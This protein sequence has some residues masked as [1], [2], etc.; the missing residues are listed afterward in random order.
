M[1][2]GQPILLI[3]LTD[4]R[5]RFH[6]LCVSICSNEKEADYAFI[7]EALKEGLKTLFNYDW[8]PDT[9]MADGAESITN[10]FM[11]AFGYTSTDQFTRLMCWPHVERNCTKNMPPRF[12]YATN[13]IADI[14]K[15]Q[16]SHCK[17]VFNELYIKFDAKWKTFGGRL[18]AQV[19]MFLQYF[20][21][22]WIDTV[23]GW[24]HGFYNYH[25]YHIM[26]VAVRER[27]LQI[28]LRCM[29]AEIAA[30]AKRGRKRRAVGGE[31]LV[32]PEE[33]NKQKGREAKKSRKSTSEAK[34]KQ[35]KKQML[36]KLSKK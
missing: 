25:C 11:K 34:T 14:Q 4:S 1:Y 21:T 27:L 33:A 28:P 20:K 3:G 5:K 7:F 29:T 24:F 6:A 35:T 8:K 2:V 15:L 16:F 22:Q 13:M 26:A 9:L 31:A 12:E 18:N 30:K 32:N 17:A 19:K 23:P 10:G 36:N